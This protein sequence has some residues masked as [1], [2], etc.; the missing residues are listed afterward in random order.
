MTFDYG[1]TYEAGDI[2]YRLVWDPKTQEMKV[3][4]KKDESAE[5]Y[6]HK[7]FQEKKYLIDAATACH[8]K[9]LI[10]TII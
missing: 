1:N 9:F 5:R 3:N 4:D 8:L 10:R 2:R 6:N 7:G